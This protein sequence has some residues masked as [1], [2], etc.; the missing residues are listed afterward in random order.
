MLGSTFGFHC[1]FRC[2][3]NRWWV[4]AAGPPRNDFQ[5]AA[6]TCGV[7]HNRWCGDFEC[8]CRWHNKIGARVHAKNEAKYFFT[9][10][11]VPNI[12]C[13]FLPEQ[14]QNNKTRTLIQRKTTPNVDFF[15]VFLP[16]V[17]WLFLAFSTEGDLRG[18][19]RFS[20]FFYVRG[21]YG[22]TQG[23]TDHPTPHG[24]HKTNQSTYSLVTHVWPS[25]KL[26]PAAAVRRQQIHRRIRPE[27][28]V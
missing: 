19:A 8:N 15:R 18:I 6:T 11:F 27:N 13:C 26:P 1:R 22:G 5:L 28:P 23:F 14:K 7:I 4:F 20:G 25:K 3:W 9:M 17:F 10:F 16:V 24:K 12:V 2:T 21:I